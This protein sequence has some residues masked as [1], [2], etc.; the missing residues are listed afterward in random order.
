M[1]MYT[2]VQKKHIQR[3]MNSYTDMLMLPQAQGCRH[4]GPAQQQSSGRQRAR[5]LHTPAVVRHTPEPTCPLVNPV[6]LISTY[7]IA[8]LPTQHPPNPPHQ[9][10]SEEKR[11]PLFKRHPEGL[12]SESCHLGLSR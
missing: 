2:Y 6:Q 1:L 4:V 12:E 7:P 10:T 8:E 9:D 5:N 11:I 3:H